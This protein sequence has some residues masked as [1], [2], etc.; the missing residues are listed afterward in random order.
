MWRLDWPTAHFWRRAVSPTW[1]PGLEDSTTPLRNSRIGDI[2]STQLSSTAAFLS[3]EYLAD[4]A[5]AALHDEADLT[6]K[7]GLVDGRGSGA[8]RDMTR[9]MLHASADAL[10][11]AFEYCVAAA[12][13]FDNDVEL[14]AELGRIGRAG[15]AAM[16]RA[17]GGVNTHR[18][19]LWALGLLCVGAANAVNAASTA[20][21]AMRA[22]KL[23]RIPDPA[24]SIADDATSHGAEVRRLYHVRG[25]VGEARAGFPHVTLLALPTL[26]QA[27]ELEF[28]EQ[29][30]RLHVLLTL[31]ARLDDTCILHRGGMTGLIAVQNSAQSVLNAGGAETVFGRKQFNILDRLCADEELSPG[32]SGDLL[33]ATLFLAAVQEEVAQC[34][35]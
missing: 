9:E 33:A 32:G 10:R 22:A 21:I 35:H 27:R 23:A 19:S 15:E 17:T 30:A 3:A 25:A 11:P 4:I 31:M 8:H 16:L 34:R 24:A 14:R 5:V 20:R 7:P 13:N 28:A 12:R 2:I 18:G 26:L 1:L 29:N 6:P